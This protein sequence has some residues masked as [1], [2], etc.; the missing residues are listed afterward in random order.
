[1]RL[2]LIE[3]KNDFFLRHC[4]FMQ[5]VPIYFKT[6]HNEIRTYM[7]SLISECCRSR[8]NAVGQ[9]SNMN[10]KFKLALKEFN[11][12]PQIIQLMVSS[13]EIAEKAAKTILCMFEDDNSIYDLLLKHEGMGTIFEA[14]RQFR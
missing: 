5:L 8:S 4:G 3:M 2:H 7:M 10:F 9:K 13:T 6:C 12:L 11:I 14:I 1:M